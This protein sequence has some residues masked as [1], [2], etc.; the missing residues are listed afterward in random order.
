M[1][2]SR[3]LFGFVYMALF[4]AKLMSNQ[5]RAGPCESSWISS[6]MRR[7]CGGMQ[8]AV[9]E[10]WRPPRSWWVPLEARRSSYTAQGRVTGM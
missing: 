1:T 7:L 8:S 10:H 6:G 5:T 3:G 4:T 2:S 9:K